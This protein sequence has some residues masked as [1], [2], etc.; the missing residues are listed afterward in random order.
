MSEEPIERLNY[1]NGQRLEAEDFRLEQGYHLRIQRWLSKSLFSAGVADGLEVYKTDDGKQVLVTPGLALDDLGRAII[2]VN[3]VQ[4]TPQAKYLCIRYA[5]RKERPEVGSCNPRSKSHEPMPQ[6]GGPARIVSEPEFIW[7]I[8]PPQQDERELVI[9]E[10]ELNPDCTVTRVASGPTKF[11]VATQASRVY[12]YALEGEKDID[13]RNPKVLR[14]HINGRTPNSVSL[15]LTAREFSK[16]YY[17]EMGKHTHAAHASNDG[18]VAVALTNSNDIASLQ[19]GPALS[20][21]EH[22]H[23]VEGINLTTADHSHTVH[24]PIHAQVDTAEVKDGNGNVVGHTVTIPEKSSFKLE[25]ESSA[26]ALEVLTD[27]FVPGAVLIDLFNKLFGNNETYAQVNL[28]TALGV[29][30]DGHDIFNVSGGSG[31]VAG[32][33]DG[34]YRVTAPPDRLDPDTFHKHN[35][36]VGVK[37]DSF[38][39]TNIDAR[40]QV[41][42]LSR[43][44]NLRVSIDGSNPDLT[45]AA[46]TSQLTRCYPAQWEGV[47]A[48]NGGP[49]DPMSGP[50][51]SGL[52]RLDL[53]G[54]DGVSFG[55]GPHE[56]EFSLADET[57]GGGCLQY[58]LY[59]E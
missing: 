36:S 30:P 25:K 38:G 3:P 43:F 48:L 23:T 22:K 26:T 51:G 1:Y 37:N 49:T 24:A 35:M 4:L 50:H 15:C 10:L 40:D 59:I 28:N 13:C 33:T 57:C 17:T 42:A 18:G 12:S 52:I 21:D 32:H 14:F 34:V 7:R 6:W 20:L 47:T 8:A 54:L 45:V 44:T 41:P 9:A 58:N 2:N 27:I 55:P 56:I 19:T 46:I 29:D 31:T 16:L 5:E 53:L 39:C 11:A